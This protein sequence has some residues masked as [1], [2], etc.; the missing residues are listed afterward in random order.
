M[1]AYHRLAVDETTTI[2]ESERGI[3]LVSRIRAEVAEDSKC[4]QTR[5]PATGSAQKAQAY[6]S[7]RL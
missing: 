1:E 7:R 3:I 6:H 5:D 2:R 4:L